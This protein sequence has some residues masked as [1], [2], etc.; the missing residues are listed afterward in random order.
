MLKAGS[1]KECCLHA[2]RAH[3]GMMQLACRD[4]IIVNY[5]RAATCVPIARTKEL[6]EAIR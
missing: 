3:Q 6:A 4:M 1:T 2:A 5:S